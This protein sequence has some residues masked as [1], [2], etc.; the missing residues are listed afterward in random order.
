[1]CGRFTLTEPPEYYAA[2]FAVDTVRA[3]GLEPSYNVAPTDPVYAVVAREGERRLGTLRW[4]L[5][6]HWAKDKKAAAR[7]INARVET[8]ASK[9][10][11]RDSLRRR[12]CLIPA[13]GFYEWQRRPSGG[14]LP[15]YIYARDGRPLAFAGLWAAWKDPEDGDWLRTCTILTRD[16]DETVRPLHDRM[17]LTLPPDRWEAW[18]DPELEEPELVLAAAAGATTPLARHPVSTMVN[19]VANN[20]PEL[21]EPIPEGPPS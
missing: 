15:H 10:A 6:P 5:V 17:P 11:F 13:D 1:M 16:P 18:L 2:A 14:K 21:I 9:P 4:G 20:W 8:V 12:R 19:K 7:H 3:A